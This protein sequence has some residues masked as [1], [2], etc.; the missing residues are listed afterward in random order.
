M[1]ISKLKNYKIQLIFLAT[2]LMLTGFLM[3]DYYDINYGFI[4]PI[5]NIEGTFI[6]EVSDDKNINFIDPIYLTFDEGNFYMYRSDESPIISL[7]TYRELK[8]TVYLLEGEDINQCV[9]NEHNSF[10]IYN[11]S[12]DE[13]FK[14]I[15]IT[16]KPCYI[17]IEP[18]YRK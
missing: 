7:G 10:Y 4:P 9:V 3:K 11:Y 16:E 15:R 2:I 8:S 12:Y 5:V 14:Y 6:R 13:V 1:I 17:G 18:Q